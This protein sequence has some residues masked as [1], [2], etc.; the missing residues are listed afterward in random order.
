M[1]TVKTISEQIEILQKR[2]SLL[3]MKKKLTVFY[4]T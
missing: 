1:K 2:G 4:K 3:M